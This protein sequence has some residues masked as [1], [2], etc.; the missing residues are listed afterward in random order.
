MPGFLDEYK[1]QQTRSLKGYLKTQ[2]SRIEDIRDAA[3]T[4]KI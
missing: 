4:K 2:K 3:K 1:D